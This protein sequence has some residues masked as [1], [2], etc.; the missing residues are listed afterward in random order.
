MW[1]ER[2]HTSRPAPLTIWYHPRER[3][4][5]CEGFSASDIADVARSLKI[6]GYGDGT[7][8]EVK[9]ATTEQVIVIHCEASDGELYACNSLGQL[10]TKRHDAPNARHPDRG[11][12]EHAW[13]AR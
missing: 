9:D 11:D 1:L 5:F 8:A 2:A 13:M 3:R 12:N 4:Y 6:F 7:R 10:R